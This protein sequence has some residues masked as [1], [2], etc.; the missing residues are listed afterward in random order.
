MLQDKISS[1]NSLLKIY[2]KM[3]KK[4]PVNFVAKVFLDKN[5]RIFTKNDLIECFKKGQ[6]SYNWLI[7]KTYFIFVRYIH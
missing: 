6:K 4:N 5:G 3:R 1:F 7:G 2:Q